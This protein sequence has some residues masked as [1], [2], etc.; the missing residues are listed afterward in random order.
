MINGRTGC[1]KRVSSAAGFDRKG[2]ALTEHL[3]RRDVQL[4]GHDAG[5][6]RDKHDE[7][8]NVA[9]EE[10]IRPNQEDA[11]R[12]H[13]VPHCQRNGNLDKQGK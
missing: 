11:F 12:R 1:D 5:E 10:G 9:V 13:L 3:G 7:D 6:G 8:V 2:N 4:I